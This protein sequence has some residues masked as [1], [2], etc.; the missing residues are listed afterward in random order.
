M[1]LSNILVLGILFLLGYQATLVNLKSER[2]WSLVAQI[3]KNLPAMREIQVWSLGRKDPLEKG[4]ATHSN[5]LAWRIPRTEEPGRLLS[6]GSQKV[7]YQTTFVNFNFLHLTCPFSTRGILQACWSRDWWIRIPPTSGSLGPTG[8]WSAG[9][10]HRALRMGVLVMNGRMC[11]PW[12]KS[13]IAH[14]HRHNALTQQFSSYWMICSPRDYGNVWRHLFV[15]Q[16]S[17]GR[18]DNW[19]VKVVLAPSGQQPGVLYPSYNA[20]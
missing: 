9:R 13:H 8:G 4:M 14:A 11:W 2:N 1:L 20:Q 18:G 6:M 15:S 17:G 16:V 12:E 3:V 10:C 19:G 7:G 5:I